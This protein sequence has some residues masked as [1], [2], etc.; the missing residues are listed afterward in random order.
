MRPLRLKFLPDTGLRGVR[1]RDAQ[2]CQRQGRF[3]AVDGAF[4]L[5]LPVLKLVEPR[6]KPGPLIYGEN[7]FEQGYLDDVRDPANSYVSM[8]LPIDEANGNEFSVRKVNV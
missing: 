4:F 8:R 7:A 1:C 5:Y 3:A 6:L 2:G